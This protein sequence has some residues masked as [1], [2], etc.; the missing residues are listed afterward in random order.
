MDKKKLAIWAVVILTLTSL[1]LVTAY[2]TVY[3]PF[4]AKMDYVGIQ[5]NNATLT[6]VQNIT[7][8]DSQSAW[9]NWN[10]TSLI[11]QVA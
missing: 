10:G 3:N 6:M 8:G 7:F 5:A 2:E 9:I 1:V 11:I 4:T